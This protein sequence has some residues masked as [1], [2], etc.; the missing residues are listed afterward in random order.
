[1]SLQLITLRQ[2]C[3]KSPCSPTR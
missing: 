1:M 2:P 3:R